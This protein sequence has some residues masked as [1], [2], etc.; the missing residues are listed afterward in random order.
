MVL[1]LTILFIDFQRG[2]ILTVKQEL[3]EQ[4]MLGGINNE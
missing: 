2:Y 1:I 4:K 3:S